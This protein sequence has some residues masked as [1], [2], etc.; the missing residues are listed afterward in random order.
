[1][2]PATVIGPYVLVVIQIFNAESRLAEPGRGFINAVTRQATNKG[3]ECH[4]PQSQIQA[5][6]SLHVEV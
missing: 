6:D 4:P 5:S 3:H 2:K 1:M